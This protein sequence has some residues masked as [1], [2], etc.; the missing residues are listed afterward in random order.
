M[1]APQRIDA[2][3]KRYKLTLMKSYSTQALSVYR[4]Q[5][6]G[7]DTLVGVGSNG[8]LFEG[9]ELLETTTHPAY[10][11]RYAL[12]VFVS[13]QTR[14]KWRGDDGY[15]STVEDP[16]K[17]DGVYTFYA[18]IKGA[19]MRFSWHPKTRKLTR[20]SLMTM[21]QA[22]YT[23]EITTQPP[24]CASKAPWCGCWPKDPCMQ[25]NTLDKT[26]YRGEATHRKLSHRVG[27]QNAYVSCQTFDCPTG[28]CLEC[29]T[30]PSPCTASCPTSPR[31]SYC[32]FDQQH[33]C[34]AYSINQKR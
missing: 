23:K 8:E 28:Q 10:I 20:Q 17:V 27:E 13:P 31:P 4:A 1:T 22:R 30:Y 16:K 9:I 3:K 11:A 18:N 21:L 2:L 26:V 33:I 25:L 14:P 19:W 5:G 7:R 6:T 32:A 34:R 12:G 24:V 29:H 15:L